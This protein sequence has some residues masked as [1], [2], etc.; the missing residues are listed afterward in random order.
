MS[1]SAHQQQSSSSRRLSN[2]NYNNNGYMSF[3][4]HNMTVMSRESSLS[5]LMVDCNSTISVSNTWASVRCLP[6]Y[7]RRLGE[8]VILRLMEL[9]PETARTRLRLESFFSERFTEICTALCEVLDV[10]VTLLGPELDEAADELA[11]L[12]AR[13]RTEIGILDG[14][15]DVG[16]AKLLGEAVAYAMETL[17]HED[18]QVTRAWKITFD[19]LATRLAV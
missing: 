9:Q 19:A 15:G 6:Q 3:S 2:N 14:H 11:V 16:G 18:V 5:D 10:I 8:Q 4:N 17:L 1:V 12:G 13:C 7:Q